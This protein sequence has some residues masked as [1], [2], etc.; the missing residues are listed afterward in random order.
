MGFLFELAIEAGNQAGSE[1]GYQ[2][3]LGPLADSE[4][5]F[6]LCGVIGWFESDGTEW[7]RVKSF[8]RRWVDTGWWWI[9]GLRFRR[10]PVSVF[11]PRGFAP[12]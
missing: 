4:P 9:G 6:C 8:W 11:W 3:Y 10:V 7:A 1:L 12:V 5:R 2:L